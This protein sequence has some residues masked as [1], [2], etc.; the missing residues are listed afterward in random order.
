MNIQFNTAAVN[1][2]VIYFS[3][4][5]FNGL[6]KWD[7]NNDEIELIDQFPHDYLWTEHMHQFSIVNAN[8][9]YFVPYMASFFTKFDMVSHKLTTVGEM[10][11]T[12]KWGVSHVLRYEGRYILVPRELKNPISV[13]CP[14][15]ETFE[16]IDLNLISNDESVNYYSDIF[17]ATIVGDTL[18]VP[19]FD[20]N[21]I[22]KIDLRLKYKSE[23]LLNPIKISSIQFYNNRFWIVTSDGSLVCRYNSNFELEKEYYLRGSSIRPY[24]SW[25]QYKDQLYLCGCLDTSLIMY[26]NKNDVWTEVFHENNDKVNDAW[27][28][29]C[30][31]QEANDKLYLFP[32]ATRN[33][34]VMN[35]GEISKYRLEYDN[36]DLQRTILRKKYDYYF[37]DCRNQIQY[38][39]EHVGLSDLIDYLKTT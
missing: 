19:I 38:E 13:F 27:A 11:N 16:L 36:D 32:S 33:M 6:F 29:I 4:K 3:A 34:Y 7:L 8:N 25:L 2:N 18:F 22:M 21:K 5:N 31:I 1:E 9:V 17:C 15:D 39:G 30:G 23:I 10:E 28:F 20:T 35:N 26:D 37:G 12:V 14:V 24:E